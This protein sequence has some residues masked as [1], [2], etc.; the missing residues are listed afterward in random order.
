MPTFK[1][2]FSEKPRVSFSC[3]PETGL[4]KQ[5]DK[6]SCD[7]GLILKKYDQTGLITHVNNAVAQY[8]D[9]TK[10]NEYQ[11][12]LNLVHK[13]QKAFDELPVDIRKRFA[14]DPG[15]FFE[16]ATNPQ[17]ADEMVKLGLAVPRPTSDSVESKDSKKE[18]SDAGEDAA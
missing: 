2:A 4:T 12:S 8:G 16:F 10:V 17:N 11:E 7:I 13:A 15:Q 9:Y 6:D 5:S 1:T 3:N 18:T 14:Y